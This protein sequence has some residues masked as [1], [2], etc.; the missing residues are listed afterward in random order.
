MTSSDLLSK[1]QGDHIYSS[2]VFRAINRNMEIEL[3]KLNQKNNY[4][5]CFLFFLFPMMWVR[6][7][8]FS[9]FKYLIINRNKY[10]LVFIDHF[11]CA[12]VIFL[13]KIFT[14]SKV[15]VINHNLESKVYLSF[16]H[17]KECSLAKRIFS[18]YQYL[19]VLVWEKIVFKLT[20]SVIVISEDDVDTSF[21]SKYLIL[22][23]YAENIY[24]HKENDGI[25]TVII[26]GSYHWRIKQF[27]IEMF[28]SSLAKKEQCRFNVIIAGNGPDEFFAKIKS[29]YHFV[30]VIQNF[31]CLGDLNGL[32]TIGVCP[33]NAGG[34]FKLKTLD[35]YR[36]NLPMV[37][38]EHGA[39]GILEPVI[40]TL[41]SFS[42]LADEIYELLSDADKLKG[43]QK[44]QSIY[45][46]KYHTESY[47]SDA[48][49]RF[50]NTIL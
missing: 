39:S 11:R 10:E 24:S 4:F 21:V 28:L 14:K 8:N 41:Y 33:D 29:N 26:I 49:N 46:S 35:Y 27:N 30:Q 36:L 48:V 1:K 5:V 37:A 31:S 45:F 42:D 34:G 3:T 15:I 22:P 20:D 16:F 9:V 13:I 18:F 47:F 2:Q 17:S 44:E 40:P 38:I 25:P 6:N 7:F 23:P 43:I 19:V 50:I 12:W 32:A